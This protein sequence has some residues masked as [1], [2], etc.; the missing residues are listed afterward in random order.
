MKR[1]S[2]TQKNKIMLVGFRP[3]IDPCDKVITLISLII[4]ILF[5]YDYG[6]KCGNINKF[7][8]PIN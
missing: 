2:N 1:E 3:H 7:L 8:L 5:S 4:T 6:R